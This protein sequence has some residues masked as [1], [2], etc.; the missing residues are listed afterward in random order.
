MAAALTFAIAQINPTVGDIEGNARKILHAHKYAARHKADLVIFPELAL[1]G[2]PP[3][4]IVLMPALRKRA[5]QQLRALARKTAKGPAMIVGTV[6]EDRKSVHNAAVLLDRGKVAFVQAKTCLPNSGIFDE[7]RLFAP[8]KGPKAVSFRGHKLGILICEDV[9]HRENIAALKKQKA[10]MAIVINASPFEAG[11]LKHR[12]QICA[13]AKLPLIYVNQIGGQDDIVF[14]GGSFVMDAKGKVVTQFPE[15]AEHVAM[16]E[17]NKK[18]WGATVNPKLMPAQE[19]VWEAMKLGLS[20]YVE[21]NNFPGVLLG[22][23]GGVDSAVTAAVA[24]DALGHERVKGVL[25]PSPYTS[26]ESMEDAHETARLLNLEIFTIPIAE[27]MQIAEERLNPIFRRSGWMSDVSLGGNLQARLRGLTLMAMSNRFGWMLLS[28]ANKSEI[29]VGYSTLYGDSCG[30]YNV[31]K[32]LYKTQIYALAAWR[33]AQSAAIPARSITKAPTAELAPGQKDEDQLPPY[34]TL[35]KILYMH[36]EQRRSA[37]EIIRA[38]FSRDMVK[39][40]VRMVRVSEYKRRQS[41]PG[42]KLSPMLFGK[43]RRYPLTN[44][45]E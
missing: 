38:G 4:D 2:Y 45:Y 22:L 37:E 34:A 15:F 8:G 43:D 44:K 16:V 6:H 41:P 3:E 9:W 20:D 21:K 17:W 13:Q 36:I 10:S 23:S 18:N 11:K 31:L 12:K 30:G 32:D 5:A 28:T 39:K 29:S 42:V 14:D 26:H 24:V 1:I 35:D 19:S 33:N 7:K 27:E 40:V 25:L